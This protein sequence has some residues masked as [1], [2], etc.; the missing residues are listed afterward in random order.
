MLSEVVGSV[1][2]LGLITLPKLVNIGEMLDPPIPIWL[3]VIRKFFPT[4]A[5]GVCR[6]RLEV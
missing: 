4:K 3:G 1:K 6:G 2:F 5:T